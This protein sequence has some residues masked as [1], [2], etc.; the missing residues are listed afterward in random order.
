MQ[1]ITKEGERRSVRNIAIDRPQTLTGETSS[2]MRPVEPSMSSGIPKE[3]PLPPFPSRPR[4]FGRRRTRKALWIGIGVVV[5][6]IILLFVWSA[7]ASATITVTPRSALVNVDDT[8]TAFMTPLEGQVGFEM[9]TV[10]EEGTKTVTATGEERVE[11][12]ATGRI[13]VFNDFDEEVQRLIKNTRFE[14]TDGLIFRIPESITVPGKHKDANGKVVP[15]LIETNVFADTAGDEYN[16]GLSDFTIPGLK[17]NNDPR[18]DSFYGRSKTPMTGGFAGIVKTASAADT[19]A[20]QVALEGELKTALLTKAAATLP[21]GFTLVPES[22]IYAFEP[23]PNKEGDS[24]NTVAIRVQGTLTALAIE[25]DKI[26]EEVARTRITDYAGEEVTFV[27]ADTL[28]VSIPDVNDLNIETATSVPLRITGPATLVWKVDT[29]ALTKDLLGKRRS[30]TPTVFSAYPGILRADVVVQPFWKRSL[31]DEA[32]DIT[33]RVAS[34]E[35]A[36]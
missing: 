28:S 9:L 10:S 31:P 36:S 19:E 24:A 8:A 34:P 12:A 17:E 6:V 23:L 16:I 30:F 32:S 35:D 27:D 5:L 1:D 11:R 18:F 15:G 4:E 20:A 14:T 25:T 22:A 29:E 21:E 7:F 2:P 26:A 33:V 13:A 3:P